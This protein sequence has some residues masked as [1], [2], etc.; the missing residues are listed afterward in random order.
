MI[1]TFLEVTGRLQSSRPGRIDWT[2]REGIPCYETCKSFNAVIN[3][4]LVVADMYKSWR[5]SVAVLAADVFSALN[6]IGK[7]LATEW[8]SP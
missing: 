2:V 6:A 4:C 7:K 8:D 1:D 5:R 3:G